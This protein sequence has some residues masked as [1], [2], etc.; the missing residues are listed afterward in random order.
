MLFWQTMAILIFL[1]N[2]LLEVRFQFSDMST[3]RECDEMASLQIGQLRRT[4]HILRVERAPILQ[5]IEFLTAHK[6]CSSCELSVREEIPSECPQMSGD[7]LPIK[8]REIINTSVRQL[9]PSNR[10]LVR[11]N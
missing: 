10:N 4:T 3:I 6:C 1:L 7:L 2:P 5:A 9:C 8:V 11:I